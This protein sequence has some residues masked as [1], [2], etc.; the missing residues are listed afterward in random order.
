MTIAPEP[1]AAMPADPDK[2]RDLFVHAVGQLTADQWE[3]YVGGACAGDPD[4]ERQ[5]GDLLRVHREAGSF[6]DRP[7]AALGETGAFLPRLGDRPAAAV[8]REGPGTVIGPYRLMEQIGEGGFGLVF[9]AEQ[10][11]PVRRRLAVKVL[12]PGMD[13][14]EVVAR[15]EAERQALALMDH[16]NIATVLDAGATPAGRPYFVME[17]VRG[18]P[19]TQFC[20]D[21]RVSPRDRLRL[22]VDLCGAVQ[23][24]HQ[25]GVIHRDL[26]PSNVLVSSHD[27]TP[28]VKVIDFGVAKAVGQGLTDKTVYTRF[29]QMVGTPL[30]MSPEQAGSS[31]LDV[32]TRTDVYALGVLLYELLTGTTPFDGHRLQAAGYDE[33]RRIIRE[34]EPARP[35]S[36]LSTIGRD[37]ATASA[38]R[39]TEPRKLTALLRGDLDWIVMK[40]L[41][42]DRTRRYDTA[43]A[44]AADVRRYL[45]D[46]PVHACPP[47]MWYLGRKFVRRNRLG[48]ATAAGVVMAVLL[49]VGSALAMQAAGTARVKAEQKQTKDANDQLQVALEREQWSLYFQRIALAVRELEAN[50]LG[51]AEELLEACPGQLRGWE[52]HYLKRRSHQGPTALRAS[53]GWLSS[54]AFSPDGKYLA[55]AGIG[56]LLGEI[57]VWDRETGKDHRTWSGHIGPIAGVAF[58]PDSK[59]L[60][61]AGWDKSVK[62]WNVASGK[63]LQTLTDHTQYVSC[64]AFSPDGKFLAA[65][66][67]DHTVRVWDAETFQHLRALTGHDGGVYGL[68]FGPDGVLATS[69]SDETVRVWDTATGRERH[70][71]RGHTGLILGLSFSPDG[72]RL[73]SGGF[74]GTVKVWDPAAGRHTLTIRDG[75]Q[76][77]TCVAFS[78]DG[79][80]LAAGGLEKTVRL[81]DVAADHEPQEA[82]TLRGHTDAVMGLAVSPDGVQIASVGLDGTARVWDSAPGPAGPE[83]LTLTG[84]TGPVFNVAFRPP[85]AG[86]AARPVLASAS[87]DTTVKF[88]DVATGKSIRTL[89]GHTGLVSRLEFSRDGRRLAS[90]DYSGTT[91]VWDVE[92]GKEVR[93][94]R[95]WGGSVALDP[96]GD[97]LAF[98]LEGAT[99]RIRD[100]LTGKDVTPAFQAH[101]APVT[102]VTFNPDGRRLLTTSWDGTAKLW[103]AATG[104]AVQTFTGHSHL[105]QSATFS[106]DGRRVGT[107]SWDKTAKVWD[108]ATGKELLTLRGHDDRVSGV[109]FSPDGKR[110]ATSSQDNTVRIWDAATGQEIAV[111]RGHTGYVLSVAFSPDG[112]RLASSGGY[113]GKGEIK[114]WDT[115]PWDQGPGRK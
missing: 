70:V 28:V 75:V 109:A 71:L 77:V 40:A 113:R 86:P 88:W 21:H 62:V 81:W 16:P 58:S 33:L 49:A 24:A 54:V 104:T 50:N 15:F 76:P 69:G 72:R 51:R 27:G 114:V 18:A 44:F 103:D 20:D 73:A 47:S 17:L 84:H 115:T 93:T 60:A 83:V 2:A 13:T 41:E 23:H 65:G 35:S 12:K 9:V 95:G 7:A 92:A 1:G 6:L 98:A 80:R 19:I 56:G 78:R 11:H 8:V 39:G 34:E 55:F 96:A 79:R 66:S 97:H 85:G 42:K 91:I 90:A 111:L 4:L 110:L 14:R 3:A 102:F 22:F 61:T 10:S 37:A 46:E 53:G 63:L 64:V 48:V 100:V 74:D 87:R 38:N 36:R 31:G 26:K 43:S 105:I 45:T 67:G 107:A 108:A 106:D 30:Y 68:A 5:V 101:L 112:K 29:T 32:D 99:V 89:A 94:F 82:V 52:W 59:R 57:K 25:K